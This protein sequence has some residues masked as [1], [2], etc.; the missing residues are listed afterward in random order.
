[1]TDVTMGSRTAND[2]KDPVTRK[3][4]N[5]FLQI[6]GDRPEIRRGSPRAMALKRVGNG[7]WHELAIFDL[8][9]TVLRN[10]AR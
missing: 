3:I 9:A 7:N 10:G 8:Y 4:L 2:S 6:S 1:V 5:L